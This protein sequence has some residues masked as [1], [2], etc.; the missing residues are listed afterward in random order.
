MMT[1]A[2][3]VERWE[4]R[5]KRTNELERHFAS[6]AQQL[7]HAAKMGRS[8]PTWRTIL[9]DLEVTLDHI[10]ALS[11]DKEAPDETAGIE[12]EQTGDGET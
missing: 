1:S 6:G 3:E 11:N 12:P 2:A 10:F 7:A 5:D 8:W 4:R 9:A